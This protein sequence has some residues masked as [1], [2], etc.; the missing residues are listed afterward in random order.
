[1]E[2]KGHL[3][4]ILPRLQD[5]LYLSIFFAA[6]MLGPRMRNMGGDLPQHLAITEPATIV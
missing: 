6:L 3:P 1:M 2:N 5:I 4:L